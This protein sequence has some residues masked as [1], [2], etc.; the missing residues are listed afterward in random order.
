MTSLDD[1]G[2]VLTIA[3]AAALHDRPEPDAWFVLPAPNGNGLIARAHTEARD[4]GDLIER[5]LGRLAMAPFGVLYCS[6]SLNNINLFV[7]NRS[8]GYS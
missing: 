6:I 1:Y 8:Q 5:G 7:S 4:G 3:E 2:P